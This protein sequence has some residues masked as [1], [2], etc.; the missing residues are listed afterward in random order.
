MPMRIWKEIQALLRQ[1]HIALGGRHF[2][3]RKLSLSKEIAK[4]LRSIDGD[5]YSLMHINAFLY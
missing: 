2:H 4:K 1:D 5:T 3:S